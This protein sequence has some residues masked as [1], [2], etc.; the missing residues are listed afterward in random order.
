MLRE[1]AATH[2]YSTSQLFW[3]VRVAVTGAP[4][5]PATLRRAGGAL[6]RET[7]WRGW[8]APPR[9]RVSRLYVRVLT[10]VS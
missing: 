9:R 3:L 6:G 5:R 10:C 8:T 1:L 4:R 2:G 7:Y